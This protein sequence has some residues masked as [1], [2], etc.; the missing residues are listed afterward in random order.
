[1]VPCSPQWDA[2]WWFRVSSSEARRVARWRTGYLA[3][4]TNTSH[5]RFL[6]ARELA[7]IWLS[8][9]H[10][11]SFPCNKQECQMQWK[12][13]I[14]ANGSFTLHKPI[15]DCRELSLLKHHGSCVAV[16]RQRHASEYRDDM[17]NLH[18]QMNYG[19]NI[20]GLAAKRKNMLSHIFWHGFACWACPYILGQHGTLRNPGS[21]IATKAVDKR[22]CLICPLK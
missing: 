10:I 8:P 22:G 19:T 2:G 9:P 5:G 21:L 11:P 4:P 1:M 16:A 3:G 6:T 18:N 15:S 12:I 7:E 13:M 20:F 14:N 17:F